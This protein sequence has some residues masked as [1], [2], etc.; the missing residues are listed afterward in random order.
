MLL[1]TL[2]IQGMRAPGSRTLVKDILTTTSFCK[3]ASCPAWSSLSTIT[4][5]DQGEASLITQRSA[6][7]SRL[8]RLELYIDV[9]LRYLRKRNCSRF[10]FALAR[11]AYG[12]RPQ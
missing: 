8:I 7:P 5:R 12:I 1:L 6:C 9:Q 3:R 11:S 10:R 2:A 4:Q